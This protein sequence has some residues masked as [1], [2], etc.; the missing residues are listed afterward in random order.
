MA[1]V[2]WIA[3]LRC[4]VKDGDVFSVRV[5]IA[6]RL[7]AA[8][9]KAGLKRPIHEVIGKGSP[10]TAIENVVFVFSRAGQARTGKITQLRPMTEMICDLGDVD[11]A[12]RAWETAA[13]AKAIGVAVVGGPP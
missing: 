2:N 4:P 12:V 13:T 7:Q 9:W 8:I 3:S 10:G 1:E 6:Q 11:L 5:D